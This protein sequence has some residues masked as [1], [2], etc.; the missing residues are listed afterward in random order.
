MLVKSQSGVP[1]AE[2]VNTEL[3]EVSWRRMPGSRTIMAT[4]ILPMLNCVKKLDFI[5]KYLHHALF[6]GIIFK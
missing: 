5:K 1:G 6:Y 2:V 4:G 3:W